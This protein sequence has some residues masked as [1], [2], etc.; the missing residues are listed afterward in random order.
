MEEK[1]NQLKEEFG[2]LAEKITVLNEGYTILATRKAIGKETKY[3]QSFL[4]FF[5]LFF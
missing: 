3:F 5:P 4:S 1:E 2:R